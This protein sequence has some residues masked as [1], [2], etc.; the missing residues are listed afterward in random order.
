MKTE[1]NKKLSKNI[2][3][4]TLK[5]LKDL[6]RNNFYNQKEIIQTIINYFL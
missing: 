3:D 6:K 5:E 4:Y 2:G 1:K